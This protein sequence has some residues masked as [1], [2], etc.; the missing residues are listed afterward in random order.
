MNRMRIKA[1]YCQANQV[2]TMDL[3]YIS[4]VKKIFD[5][6]IGVCLMTIVDW[7]SRQILS[8]RP[9]DNS[10]VCRQWMRHCQATS[11]LE[12]SILDQGA[13]PRVRPSPAN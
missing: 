13:N 5:V 3:T 9:M 2:W 8:W 10:A 4:L 7:Y 6:F 1:L 11:A 12:S